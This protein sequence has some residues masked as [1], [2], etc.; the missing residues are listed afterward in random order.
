MNNENFF[1]KLLAGFKDMFKSK[2]NIRVVSILSI[3]L[4]LVLFLAFGGCNGCG[5][6]CACDNGGSG[7]GAKAETLYDGMEV[8]AT[9]IID[10]F[11]NVAA[12]VYYPVDVYTATEDSSEF[13]ANWVGRAA[14]YADGKFSIQ[15]ELEHFSNSY[16]ADG[17]GC[18]SFAEVEQSVKDKYGDNP[19]TYGDMN[20]GGLDG[21]WR[22]YG[23]WLTV[24]LPIDNGGNQLLLVHVIPPELDQN[25]ADAT[26]KAAALAENKELIALLGAVKITT[27]DAI[28]DA[29]SAI[30]YGEA[31]EE[32]G[33]ASDN[34]DAGSAAVPD[35]DGEM[36][37]T[38]AFKALVPNGWKAFPVTDIE[39]DALDPDALQICKGGES[40][41]DIFSKPY[42]KI[43]FYGEGRSLM[44]PDMS[45][46]DNAEKL[47]DIKVGSFTWHGF[48]AEGMLGDKTANLWTDDM[49]GVQYQATVFFG[50][51]GTI[52]LD[53]EGL[54]AILGTLE[55]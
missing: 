29:S 31:G 8:S 40:E 14:I 50:T 3:V 44:T 21:F 28:P 36:Y 10:E 25:A 4:F 17:E 7:G 51:D 45:W 2:Q 34:S 27:V 39:P 18:A 9:S 16:N 54:L 26:E 37:D 43:D 12:T 30:F 47:D 24:Y 5:G 11:N 53:D 32:A 6:G 33:D 48:T 23:G 41:W 13:W 20:V 38:G 19:L 15:P 49:N 35:V 1:T 55:A 22:V 46:Y 42:V 52:T